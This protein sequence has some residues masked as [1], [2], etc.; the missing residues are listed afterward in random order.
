[1]RYK[2]AMDE[3]KFCF[4]ICSNNKLFL[5]ECL[6]YISKINVPDGYMVEHLIIKEAKS[7]TSGYNEGMKNSNA[8]YKIYLHQDVFILNRNLLYDI[9]QIFNSDQNIGMIGMVGTQKMPIDSVMWH[10]YRK[11]NL[12]GFNEVGGIDDSYDYS[13]YQFNIEDGLVDVVA[14]DG[15]FMATSKDLLWREDLFD[16]WDFYDVSQ[17]FEMKRKGYRIVVPVQS[18]PW[19]LHDDMI[20]DFN[21]YDKYRKVC[22]QEYKEFYY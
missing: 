7:M 18:S 19:C 11:G 6:Y 15:L 20:L 16:R 9:L 21:E 8:K 13:A 10:G 2:I 12:Y 4:I 3:Y 14:I 17:S 1:M 5:D 22:L